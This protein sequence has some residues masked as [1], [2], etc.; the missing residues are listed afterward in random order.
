MRVFADAFWTPKAGNSEAEY[1]D[2]FWPKQPINGEFRSKFAV[3]DGA[4]ETSFSGLWAR[5]LVRAYCRGQ[6][7]ANNDYSGLKRLQRCWWRI[8]RSKPLPWFAEQKLESGTFAALIGLTFESRSSDAEDGTWRACAVGDSCLVQMRGDS[9]IAALPLDC[10]D[11]FTNSPALLPTRCDDQAFEQVIRSFNGEW[12]SG[13]HF[14][15]MTD[16][17]AAWFFRATEAG[18][19]PWVAL[20]DLDGTRFVDWVEGARK[21]RKMRNDDVT[22][23]RIETS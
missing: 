2:A 14:Y 1:E 4:T 12:L 19:S 11:S 3:G 20:R 21:S 7:D 8:V 17:L 18:D 23:Y 10:S 13:D 5:Q 16:A 9:L 15:L 22:L 6:F